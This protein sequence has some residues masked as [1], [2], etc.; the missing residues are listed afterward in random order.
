M[1]APSIQP[2]PAPVVEIRPAT[3][4]DL[5]ALVALE[6]AAFASDRAERR[7]IRHAIRSASMS[8]LV[9][10]T[11]DAAGQAT[12][13]GSATLE[14]RRGSRSARLS[15]IAVSPARAGLGLGSLVLDAAEADA[16]THGCARLRLEV[17]ADN[18]AGIR[19]YERRGYTR[20]AVIPDYYED[21]MEAWRYEKTL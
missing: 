9:A 3:L 10:L 7:A 13:V 17:R 1:R 4:A 8:L 2:D 19:L 16:R 20:F 14:R 18:G 11:H 12:L 21:G 6:H 5:D 15:S